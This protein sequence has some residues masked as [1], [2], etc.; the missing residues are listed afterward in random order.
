MDMAI[1]LLLGSAL[2]WGG[3]ALLGLS[4]GWGMV[5]SV[6]IGAAGSIVGGGVLGPMIGAATA[7]PGDFD[8]FLLFMAL[9]GA[10]GFLIVG[11]MIHNRF[12]V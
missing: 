3:F 7:H 5:I 10:A 12:A 9:T 11:N 1:W 6:V 2:G 4:A 8:P